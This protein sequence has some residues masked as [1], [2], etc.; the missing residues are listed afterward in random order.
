[1]AAF[2]FKQ[3]INKTINNKPIAATLKPTRFFM[4]CDQKDKPYE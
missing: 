1:L 3:F 2:I 4:N